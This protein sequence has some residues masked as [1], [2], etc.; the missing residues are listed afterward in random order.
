[1]LFAPFKIMLKV[2]TGPNPTDRRQA[3]VIRFGG[4]LVPDYFVQ[5]FKPGLSYENK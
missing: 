5:T 4:N 3:E 2:K 1:M